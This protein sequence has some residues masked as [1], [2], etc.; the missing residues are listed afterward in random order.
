MNHRWSFA[1]NERVSP[2]IGILTL[3]EQEMLRGSCVGV[4]GC[5][6]IGGHSASEL[7]YWGIGALKLA[8]FDVF[9]MSN[10]NRQL[11]AAFSTIGKPKVQVVSSEVRDIAPE[12]ELELYPDGITLRNVESF[13][14]GCNAIIDSIDYE[15]PRASVAM[16]RTARSRGITVY[17]AQCV[18][19]GASLFVFRH[20]PGET[21]YEELIGLDPETPLEKVSFE[22][23]NLTNLCPIFPSYISKDIIRKVLAGEMEAPT[24]ISG[25]TTA[26]GLTVT[27]LVM[28]ITKPDRKAKSMVAF[29]PY[30][31][32]YVSK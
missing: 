30:L 19:F 12:I 18:G 25:Q 4:A 11:F 6:A 3:D 7:A 5:G 9:E 1:Y 22:N 29:D 32:E 15:K 24:V 20:R 16:N 23:I 2:N 21:T 31:G 10:A 14:S 28:D 26:V 27:E 8:D 13:V 17:L